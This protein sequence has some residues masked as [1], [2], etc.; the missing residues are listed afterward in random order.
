MRLEI[1]DG[2]AQGGEVVI[3]PE[4]V[5]L[6]AQVAQP[7]DH[8]VLGLVLEDLL[9]GLAGDVVGRHQ[10]DVH[11]HEHPLLAHA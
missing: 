9:I 11:Q 2:L 10:V 6:V 7:V 4:L 5:H 8:V 3:Q 1:L